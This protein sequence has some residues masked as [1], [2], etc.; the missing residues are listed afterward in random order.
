M[1]SLQSGAKATLNAAKECNNS[2]NQ[3][4][5]YDSFVE[6][7]QGFSF[8][9]SYRASALQ[10]RLQEWRLWLYVPF[11]YIDNSMDLTIV[12]LVGITT[13]RAETIV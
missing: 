6:L 3:L 4:K 5:A 2:R 11:I 1:F 9:Q 12:S 10:T 8:T 7:K 13:R